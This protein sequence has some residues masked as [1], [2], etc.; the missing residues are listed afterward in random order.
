MKLKDRIAVVTGASR[1]LGMATARLFHEEGA[2]VICADV[3]ELNAQAFVDEHFGGSPRALY[4][5][6]DITRPEQVEEL[7]R[8]VGQRFG[9]LNVLV[10]NAA[11]DTIGT[12]ETTTE[13]EFLRVLN[14]NV[15]GTFVMTRHML[16]LLK[17]GGE[18]G[19]IVNVASNIGL[20]GM[21]ERVAYTTSKGAVVNFTRSVAIDCA[22]LGIRVNAIAPGAI[23][24]EMVKEFFEKHA[25]DAFRRKVENW[26]ALDRFAQPVEIARGILFLA[27]GESS[28]STGSIM[29]M[30]G[31]YTCGK[32]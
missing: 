3:L 13:E 20:M 17:K 9:R 10:N 25:D 15:Y 27:S 8:F 7:A 31:G 12:V 16:P 4:R 14:V 24:T 11:V 29:S 28:Y 26:H 19:A 2:T 22:P 18:G 32:W 1:G 6:V 23:A 5:R 30:D 21:G